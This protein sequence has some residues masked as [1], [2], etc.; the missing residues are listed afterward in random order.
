MLEKIPAN[1]DPNLLVGFDTS[2]D[3]GV[4]RLD[5]DQAIVVTA[6]FITPPVDDPFVFGQIAA[7]NSLSDVYAMGG[8]PVACLNLVCFPFDKLGAEVLQGI[9]EGSHERIRQAGAVLAG[10]HSVDD[11]EPKF[12]L[13]VTGIVH[14]D[15]YWANSGAK[16]G[17]CLILTKPLGSGVLLN[18]NLKGKV[19]DQAMKECLDSLISLNAIASKVLRQFD[20][21]AATDVTG[22]G[23]AGHA[24]EIAAGSSVS[25][26]IDTSALPLFSEA[27]AMYG[28]GFSTGVNDTNRARLATET[29]IKSTIP[30]NLIEVLVDPQTNGGLLVSLPASDS[31][32]ALKALHDAGVEEAAIIGQVKTYDGSTSL[33]FV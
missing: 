21:H 24:S 15:K 23:I 10:G 3:A 32:R 9:T 8:K 11:P 13:S 27:L 31:D 14:P 2:D 5:D 26:E 33:H 29:E 6:D 30:K 28:R 19:S 22:F 18:A 4:Y 20:V 12:G 16:A 25:I 17:D 1:S 7:A